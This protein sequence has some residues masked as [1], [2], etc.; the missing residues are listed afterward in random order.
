MTFLQYFAHRG[1]LRRQVPQPA[2]EGLAPP[3]PALC[4]VPLSD[5]RAA[6]LLA[7]VVRLLVVRLLVVRAAYQ[8][9][10]QL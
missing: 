5:W 2:V 10:K 6:A 8:S 1:S 7:V 9:F 3:R 4:A